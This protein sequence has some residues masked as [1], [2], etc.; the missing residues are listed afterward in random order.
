MSNFA[1]EYCSAKFAYK[2]GLVQHKK[3]KHPAVTSSPSSKK[4]K[5]FACEYC[6]AKF[7]YKRNLVQH[8]K[9]KHPAVASLPSS[10]SSSSSSS[11]SSSFVCR[12]CNKM[13]KHKKH[14]IDHTK[15]AHSKSKKVWKCPFCPSEYVWEK[16]FKAHLKR[17]HLDSTR[18]RKHNN[19]KL[20]IGA[21]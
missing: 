2:R 19:E 12:S 21:S 13:F 15:I 6:S 18:K 20:I 8:K 1:C 16:G 7:A 14:L 3:K 17:K 10:P 4:K 9:K 11:S 5:H